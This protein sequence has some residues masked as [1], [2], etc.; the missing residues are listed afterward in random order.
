MIG[1]GQAGNPLNAHPQHAIAQ[2][3]HR[4]TDGRSP[5]AALI[6]S[7]EKKMKPAPKKKVLQ[8]RAHTH[9]K[10]KDYALPAHALSQFRS[11]V[12]GHHA[13]SNST[14]RQQNQLPQDESQHAAGESRPRAAR[15][16]KPWR[17]ATSSRR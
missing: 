2:G 10:D 5:S 4:P 13:C 6:S 9:S 7:I 14:S 16:A 15:T 1:S 12:T 3:S 8:W 11:N 17:H